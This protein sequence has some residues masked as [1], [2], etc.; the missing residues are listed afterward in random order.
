MRRNGLLAWGFHG[1]FIAFIAAP[2]IAIVLVSF[3]GK[4]YLSMPFDGAS[5]RWYRAL[6]TAPEF[7][8]ALRVSLVLGVCSASIAL[9][10]AVPAALA[11][12]RWSFPGHATVQG[13]LMSPLL[14]PNVV[15]GV[16]FLRFFTDLGLSGT[17]LGL[18]CAHVV[19]VMPY[20]LRLSLAATGGFDLALEQA[21]LSL[22]ASAFTAFRRVTLR[23]LLPGLA[24]GWILAFIHS[25]DE[26]TM[27]T[28]IASPSLTPLPV[29]LYLRIEDSIDPMVAAVSTLMIV[30]ALALVIALDRLYGLDRIFAGRP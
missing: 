6:L 8:A 5:L 15:L 22:G 1:L 19:V 18:V 30:G 27:S 11:L 20:A 4:G 26:L 10:L 23:L 14:I 17:L 25:F 2:L 28:F 12:S 24:S 3:T 16:A 29:R 13:I 7:G 21:A 9:V